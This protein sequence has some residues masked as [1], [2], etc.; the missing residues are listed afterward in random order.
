MERA[1]NVTRALAALQA[2]VGCLEGAH[3]QPTCS[4][5]SSAPSAAAPQ[6][7][8]LAGLRPWLLTQADQLPGATVLDGA[9]TS[10]QQSIGVPRAR[11]DGGV[12]LF[13]ERW[14]GEAKESGLVAEL[15]G[16]YLRV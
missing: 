9:F 8:V 4:S 14:L 7:D 2:R 11:A 5:G 10:V 15:I 16:K 12:S 1:T 6:G 13:L 3:M